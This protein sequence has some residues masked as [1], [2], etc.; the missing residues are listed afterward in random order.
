MDELR[1]KYPMHSLHY[2][3]SK[4]QNEVDFVIQ[5]EADRADAV[6]AKITPRALDAR[7]LLAFR[8]LHPKGTNHLVCPHVSEPYEFREAGL[9]IRVS[10]PA[11]V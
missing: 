8:K 9:A 2:W 11:D 6:E 7:S 5:R 1:A 4:S 3:R 10:A